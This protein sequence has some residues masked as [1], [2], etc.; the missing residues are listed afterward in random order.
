MQSATHD[1]TS[2]S[3]HG[4]SKQAGIV[5]TALWLQRSF[6]EA[7]N[8]KHLNV[9]NFIWSPNVGGIHILN[10]EVQNVNAAGLQWT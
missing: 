5:T 9:F 7:K 2:C 8:F 4:N 1:M 6:Q 3:I 10:T